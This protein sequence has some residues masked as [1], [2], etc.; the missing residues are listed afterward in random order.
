VRFVII[1][2]KSM[3][4]LKMLSIIDDRLRQVFPDR[5]DQP[6]GG[7]NVLLC[8]DFFQLPPVNGRPL[9]ATK[10]TGLEATKGQGLYRAFDRTVQLTEVMRQQGT[11]ETAIRF[12]RALS[13][14]RESKLSQSS[15]E[16][17]CTR[18]Q[19]QLTLDEVDGFQSAL[20]LYFTNEEVRER[21]YGQLAAANRPV[22]RILSEHTG[23]NA[24]RASDEE[25][26]NLPTELLVCIGAQVMLTANL[27]TE[28]GLVNGSIGTITDILWDAGQDPSV[29]MPSLLL[30]RFDEYSG[31][32]FPLYRPKIVP[33]FPTTRQFEFKGVLCT[34]KQFPLRLAYAITVHKSQGLT[35]SRVV[36][37]LDQREHCLGLSYVAVSRVKALDG[38]MFESPFDYSRFN[39]HNTPTARDRELDITFRKTQLL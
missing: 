31:P 33:I 26:D 35:L 16:L 27:W 18:V 1:D 4:D 8:G 5:A 32:D 12:R 7:V 30:V 13:E 21:N 39:S 15:W 23:R 38:L 17:L 25:A 10:V 11:D 14:L 19:N 28:K 22:K 34:R 24:S 20:R 6:F 37:N 29:S 36:L 2:E 3:I 9:Y